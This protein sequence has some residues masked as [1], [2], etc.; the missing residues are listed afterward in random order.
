MESIKQ[1]KP[2]ETK[3]TP[4]K[5]E[6]IKETLKELHEID[7]PC[8]YLSFNVKKGI[9]K[10]KDINGKT[11]EI[12]TSQEV[13]FFHHYAQE[14]FFGKPVIS[15]HRKRESYKEDWEDDDETVY[16]NYYIAV[17]FLVDKNNNPNIKSLAYF[18]RPLEKLTYM[19][20]ALYNYNGLNPSIFKKRD[21]IEF[22]NRNTVGANED[23]IVALDG[24]VYIGE[25]TIDKIKLK[26]DRYLLTNYPLISGIQ[27]DER[28]CYDVKTNVIKF[29]NS[30]HYNSII[31]KADERTDA[32]KLENNIVC[33]NQK[34][35]N[36]GNIVKN[37][38]INTF[39]IDFKNRSVSTKLV[40]NLPTVHGHFDCC[41]IK[42]PYAH[43][44]DYSSVNTLLKANPKMANLFYVLHVVEGKAN[45][46]LFLTPSQMKTSIPY[47]EAIFGKDAVLELHDFRNPNSGNRVYT[48][49][50]DTLGRIRDEFNLKF[51]ENNNG[52]DARS[53]LG[54][55]TDSLRSNDIIISQWYKNSEFKMPK[56]ALSERGK[57]LFKTISSLM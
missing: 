47:Y 4:K 50:I 45:R 1:K 12:N 16:Y 35:G 33:K 3:K 56:K 15:I 23:S 7:L 34:Y 32:I 10:F 31:M 46:T 27:Y 37:F 53:A 36:T 39:T 49:M 28:P 13:L 20:Y 52:W 5:L 25:K 38:Q 54:R 19:N 55:P 26:D 6:S 18:N 29:H 17:H 9:F 2:K 11:Q 42:L 48:Y 43:K 41:G 22:L 44:G 24:D 40:K 8:K 51:D 30:N 14:Y 57:S 21:I